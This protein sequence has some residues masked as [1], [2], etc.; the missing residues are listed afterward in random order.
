MRNAFDY[1][2]LAIETG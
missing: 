1:L 2:L